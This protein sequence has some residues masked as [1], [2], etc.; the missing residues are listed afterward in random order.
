MTFV[1]THAARARS[2]SPD[3]LR[4]RVA[5]IVAEPHDPM[6]QELVT[7]WNLAVQMQPAAAVAVR[8]AAD[9]RETV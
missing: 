1:P 4:S 3:A 2:V 9:V 5:G 6:Y 7:A 8:S